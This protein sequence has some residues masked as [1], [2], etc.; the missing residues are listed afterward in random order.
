[1]QP[2]PA[3]RALTTGGICFSLAEV[4]NP[5]APTLE[6]DARLVP[7]GP[8]GSW[9]FLHF[10]YDPVKTFGTKA[11]IPVCGTINGF[12][13]RSSL[14]PM[15]G[16]HLLCINKQMQAGAKV[17]PGDRAHFI[18]QRD[19]KPRTVTVPP[20]LK[21][22]LAKSPKAKAIFDKLSHSHRKEDVLWLNDAK[23]PETAQ[24]RLE[25]LMAKLLKLAEA[26]S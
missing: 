15:D 22:A 2:I 4:K 5:P 10:P 17:K 26:K 6:F 9:C 7:T 19:D 14:S 8:K 12:A 24:R 1:M 21:K 20:A 23:K 25:K 11:R 18:M 3:K 13:F 16:K